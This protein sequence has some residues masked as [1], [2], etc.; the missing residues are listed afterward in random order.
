MLQTTILSIP[1]QKKEHEPCFGSVSAEAQGSMSCHEDSGDIIRHAIE[2][3]LLENYSS[4]PSVSTAVTY[5][6]ILTSLRSYLQSQ[7][8]DLDSSE[9]R[10]TQQI[11]VWANLRMP[12]SRHRGSVAPATYNQRMAA[13][14]S[15]YS[16]ASKRGN[17]SWPNPVDQLGRN[18]V[19]KYAEAQAL[20]VRQVRSR[21]KKIDRSTARGLRDYVLL[22]VALNTGRSARELANLTWGSISF[23][24]KRITL[25]FE[26]GRG[27]KVMHDAL[28]SRLSNLLLAYLR[29]VYGESLSALS[30]QAPIWISFSDRTY[31]QAIGQQTI[32]DI[33]EAHLGVSKIRQ[34]RHT[35]A[36]VMDQVGASVDTIQARLGHESRSTTD[37]YLA[38]LREAYNP[39]ATALADT[40]GLE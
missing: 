2:T 9:E 11:Q 28:D 6:K 20:D 26:G 17:Y 22:Q 10:L 15:F 38:S 8:L 18:V 29:A 30:P 7:G 19:R 12:T 14:N 27:G 1:E 5:R 13:I 32:A 33:C 39:Y 31:R 35:F 23:Q 3:W 21:L 24:G 40:F 37:V 4:T 34:L 25:V 16:W 36:L